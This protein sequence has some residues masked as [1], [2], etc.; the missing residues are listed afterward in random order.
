MVELSRI[1]EDISAGDAL[2]RFERTRGFH[3][4]V[5]NFPVSERKRLAYQDLSDIAVAHLTGHMMMDICTEELED[6]KERSSISEVWDLR[7][8]MLRDVPLSEIMDVMIEANDVT[9]FMR[10]LEHF[11]AFGHRIGG[12]RAKIKQAE[13]LKRKITKAGYTMSD[14]RL[15]M[16]RFNKLPFRAVF[17]TDANLSLKTKHMV[18]F[19]TVD[20][21][22]Q[23][24]NLPEA[25][26][27]REVLTAYKFP[28]QPTRQ[29]RQDEQVEALTD[30][31]EQKVVAKELRKQLAEVPEEDREFHIAFMRKLLPN[32]LGIIAYEE[33][34][35][36]DELA[37]ETKIAAGAFDEATGKKPKAR[38]A[39]VM[40]ALSGV[41]GLWNN[42]K[43]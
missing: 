13:I 26:W 11:D 3:P 2:D 28:D 19:K 17:D 15:T 36:T 4:D 10:L 34:L 31:V 25:L 27:A 42:R 7:D 1:G 9:N 38:F 12:E 33:N 41:S 14:E 20:Q 32:M 16:S 8:E 39:R 23:S 24:D 6:K 18:R 21:I 40:T 43:P 29:Q 5:L 22:I 30:F 35:R 37:R